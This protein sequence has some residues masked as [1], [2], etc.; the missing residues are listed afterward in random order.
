MENNNQVINKEE[1]PVYKILKQI[2]EG[3]LEAKDLS[4]EMR[5]ESVE[6]LTLEGYSVSSIAQL[7]DRSEKTIKRDLEDIWQRNSKRPTPEIA[8]QLIAELSTKSKN[9]VSH[10]MRIA[11][12]SEGSL[13]ERINAERL[14]WEIQNQTIERLQSLGYLPSA[15]QKIVGDIYHHDETENEEKT[16]TELKEELTLL[17]KIATD[18]GVLDD[19]TKTKINSL[20]LRIEQADIAQDITNLTKKKTEENNQTK[21]ED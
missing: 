8:L 17:E 3:T 18:N 16:L 21:K 20:K 9:Q 5:Q 1:M 15:P 10:L 11:R 19:A 13:Q 6:V 2:K 12:S 7:L 4:K 14:A